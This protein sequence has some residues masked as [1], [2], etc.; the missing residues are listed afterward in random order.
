MLTVASLLIS[1]ITISGT[2]ATKYVHTLSTGLLL[3]SVFFYL[4]VYLP[5]WKRRQIV[6][7]NFVQEYDRTKLSLINKFLILS[8]SQE[9]PDRENLLVKE[10]FR[11]YFKGTN[12][13]GE[14]RWSAI[15]NGLQS[16]EFYLREVIFDLRLLN[17][18]IRFYRSILPIQ[19]AELFQF[20]NRLSQAISSVELTQPDY[21]ETK[22]FCRFLWQLFTGY[23]FVDGYSRAGYIDEM[24]ERAR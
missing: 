13:K 4:V 16:N 17:D 2:G 22:S 24:I 15:A 19:D 20:L 1:I 23:N 12:D 11:R 18:E 21:D 8:D 7:R 10:E 5:D 3:S 14:D 9:Y 6:V